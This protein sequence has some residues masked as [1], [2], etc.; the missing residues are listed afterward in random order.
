M[1]QTIQ[2]QFANWMFAI[3]V[4]SAAKNKLDI[5]RVPCPWGQSLV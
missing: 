5:Q 2:Y 4:S 1:L 3:L